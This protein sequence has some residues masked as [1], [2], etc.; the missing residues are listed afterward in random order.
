MGFQPSSQAPSV[1]TGAHDS[2]TGNILAASTTIA[3]LATAIVAIFP[4]VPTLAKFTLIQIS[5]R[6]SITCSLALL[7][8]GC[9][10]VLSASDAIHRL[11]QE[12]NITLLP[13]RSDCSMSLLM[14]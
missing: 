5:G 9:C 8:C 13:T 7:L 1:S 2:Q 10:A 11:K 14:L 12:N 3:G 4:A 6:I